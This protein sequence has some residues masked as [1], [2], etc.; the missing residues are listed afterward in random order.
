MVP[1]RYWYHFGMAMTVRLP[2]DLDRAL[3]DLAE[4]RHT[5]K[6]ALLVEAADRLVRSDEKTA[7]VLDAVDAVDEQYRD[8]IDRLRDA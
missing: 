6:H 8:T 5:S 7:R 2:A 4:A 3:G 1:I